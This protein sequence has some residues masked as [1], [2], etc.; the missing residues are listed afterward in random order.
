MRQPRVTLYTGVV[1]R[2]VFVP[3]EGEDGLVHL[4]GVE[5][6]ESHEQVEVFH[7]QARDSQE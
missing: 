7:C 5:H 4:L 3:S 6:P 2:R 1:E